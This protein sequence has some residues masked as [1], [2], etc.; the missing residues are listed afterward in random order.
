MSI[1]TRHRQ[2]SLAAPR[3]VSDC[4]WL[5]L[6]IPGKHYAFT[7]KWCPFKPKGGP[8]RSRE[9]DAEAGLRGRIDAAKLAEG[10]LPA[11]AADVAVIVCGPPHM[12]EDMREALLALG[13]A[14]ECLV[15]LKALSTLQTVN[16]AGGDPAVA[17]GKAG[18]CAPGAA[19]GIMLTEKGCCV[20][21]TARLGSLCVVWLPGMNINSPGA[22]QP[23][24]GLQAEAEAEAEAA[25]RAP[26]P[27]L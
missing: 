1:S 22:E 13:H 21:V 14:P 23:A 12:W 19:A 3:H 26:P 18:F 2:S 25:W 17:A 6:P 24:E 7:T 9:G 5:F 20:V 8:L 15:E 16:V 27:P 10:L 4:L 11:P